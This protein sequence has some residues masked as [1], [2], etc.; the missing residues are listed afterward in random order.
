MYYNGL[1]K[2]LDTDRTDTQALTT[3]LLEVAEPSNLLSSFDKPLSHIY[4]WLTKQKELEVSDPR[5]PAARQYALFA[6][7]SSLHSD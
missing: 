5:P 1:I 2:E 4:G 7:S 3:W 6:A